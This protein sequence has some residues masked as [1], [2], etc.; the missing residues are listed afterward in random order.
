MRGDV[1]TIGAMSGALWGAAN[2]ISRL[3]KSSLE[4]LEDRERIQQVAEALHNASVRPG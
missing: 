1:D 2:G 4:L 3:P